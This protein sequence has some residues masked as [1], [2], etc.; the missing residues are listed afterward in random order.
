MDKF[1]VM[2]PDPD[3]ATNIWKESMVHIFSSCIYLC[4]P[5][6]FNYCFFFNLKRGLILIIP[7]IT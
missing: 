3:G 2:K 1:T 7:S 5:Q 4:Y 6:L